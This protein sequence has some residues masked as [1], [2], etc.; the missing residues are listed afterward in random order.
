[1]TEKSPRVNVLVRD[2]TALGLRWRWTGFDG[3]TPLEL[4]ELLRLRQDVFVREQRCLYGD[5]DG[6]DVSALHGLGTTPLGELVAHARLLSPTPARDEP[7]IGR[8]VVA[9]CWRSKGVGRELMLTALEVADSRYPGRAVRV[10]AQ[11]HLERFYASLG[12]VRLGPDYDDDGI[13][14]C[15]MRRAAS[16]APAAR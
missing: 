2:S 13:P 4:Y 15:D 1:M 10:S 6:R 8:V 12:F 11:A 5:I 9:P 3:L 7:S 14:H 16:A